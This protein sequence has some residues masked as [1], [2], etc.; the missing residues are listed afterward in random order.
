MRI[1]NTDSDS[2]SENRW[3]LAVVRAA[4]NRLVGEIQQDLFLSCLTI[5]EAYCFLEV[6]N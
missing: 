4:L 3:T 2:T 6:F 5:G 1:L